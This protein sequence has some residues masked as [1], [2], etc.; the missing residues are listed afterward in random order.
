MSKKPR[1]RN[2]AVETAQQKLRRRAKGVRRRSNKLSSFL[3]RPERGHEERLE[4]DAV[5]ETLGRK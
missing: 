4:A 2:R 1:K 5:L 3:Y